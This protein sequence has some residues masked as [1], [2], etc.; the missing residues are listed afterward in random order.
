MSLV[1]RITYNVGTT[2]ELINFGSISEA[3]GGSSININNLIMVNVLAI[4][5]IRRLVISHQI[6]Q[7]VKKCA[8]AL[9]SLDFVP[10]SDIVSIFLSFTSLSQS[11]RLIPSISFG[12]FGGNLSLPLVNSND[13]DASTDFRDAHRITSLCQLLSTAYLNPY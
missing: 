4:R 5:C 9:F 1:T 12:E 6:V 2:V 11:V 13:D 8:Y 3:S 7:P 10:L